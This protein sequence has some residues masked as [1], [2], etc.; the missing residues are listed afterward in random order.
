M[1]VSILQAPTT[2]TRIRYKWWTRWLLGS[3]SQ[4]QGVS[5]LAFHMGQGTV[6]QIMEEG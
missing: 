3:C 1:Q 6:R 5:S 2:Q 4:N